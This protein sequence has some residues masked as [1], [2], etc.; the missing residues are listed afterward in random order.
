MDIHIVECYSNT[1]TNF[2]L[3]Y[4]SYFVSHYQSKEFI[5]VIIYEEIK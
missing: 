2:G 1:Y 5:F 3:K 4:C